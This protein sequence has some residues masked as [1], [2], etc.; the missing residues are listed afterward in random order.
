MRIAFFTDV[1]ADVHTLASALDQIAHLGCD[2]I[3]CGGDIVDYG[4]FPGETI[5]LL[6]ERQIPCVRGNH[7]RW[8]Q[9]DFS[10]SAEERRWLADLPTTWRCTADGV[11]VVV[12][13]GSPRADMDGLTH[14]ETDGSYARLMLDKADADILLVGHTHRPFV[15]HLPGGGMIANSGALLADPAYQPEE[16]YGGTFGV[17]DTRSRAF[18]VHRATDGAVVDPPEHW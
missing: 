17:L 1:H 2:H 15:W 6:R 12:V 9:K 13:H 3:V 8:A 7:D 10:L 11:R 16:G 14:G 5:S 18:T 4:L